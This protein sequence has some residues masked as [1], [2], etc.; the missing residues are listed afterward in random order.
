MSDSMQTV[1]REPNDFAKEDCPLTL[2]C[3]LVPQHIVIE[4]GTWTRDMYFGLKV[5][6][7]RGRLYI[8]TWM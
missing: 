5:V 3:K 8:G 1:R 4:L 6:V 7:Y 2:N